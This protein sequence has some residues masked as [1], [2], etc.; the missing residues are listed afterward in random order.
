MTTLDALRD[1]RLLCGCPEDV[2]ARIAPLVAIMSVQPGVFLYREGDAADAMY[3]VLDGAV[4]LTR[5]RHENPADDEVLAQ[6][7]AGDFFADM[8]LLDDKPHTVAAVVT[9]PSLLG[10]IDR[11]GIEEI[12]RLAPHVVPLNFVRAVHRRVTGANRHFT[13]E[14]LR[15]ERLYYVGTMTGSIIHDFNTPLTA[16]RCACDLLE[17]QVHDETHRRMAE[18]IKKSVDRMTAMMQELLDYTLGGNAPLRFEPMTVRGLMAGL[19][20]QCLNEVARR[21]IE[22]ERRI[23]Y[24]G[25]VEIDV[26]RFERMLVNIVKN[27][28]EAMGSKGRLRLTVYASGEMVVFE[29]EDTGK[30]MPPEV[31]A[32]IFDPFFTHA[33]PQGTGL[34]MSMARSVVEAHHG[35]IRVESEPGKGTKFEVRIPRRA[36]SPALGTK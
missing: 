3:L 22:V 31:A 10:R 29:I 33:K 1:N 30:G 34:G 20:E 14:I 15:G 5:P 12:L 4:N 24:E 28:R 21:G 19:D 7:A 11:S 26:G 23:D 35:T 16:I 18:V 36:A 8:A 6:A 13:E 27:A 17:T 25:T 9:E 32:K 2:L